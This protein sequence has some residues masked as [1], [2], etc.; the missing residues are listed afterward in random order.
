MDLDG[1]G[2]RNR[3]HTVWGVLHIFIAA[4]TC[5]LL[6]I[7]QCLLPIAVQTAEAAQ[8]LNGTLTNIHGVVKIQRAGSGI[9]RPASSGSSVG[10]GDAVITGPSGSA[11]IKF[12]HGQIELDNATRVT[13]LRCMSSRDEAFAELALS[14]GAVT[15]L[16]NM[17]R[18][19]EL[20]FD[21]IT[22][23][24]RAR[25][26]GRKKSETRLTVSHRA[27]G[28]TV[29]DSE[30]GRWEYQPIIVTDLPP[31]VQAALNNNPKAAE[32]MKTYIDTTLSQTALT[33]YEVTTN[34][35]APDIGAVV[36]PEKI[37]VA[38]TTPTPAVV[39][40]VAIPAPEPPAPLPPPA[41]APTPP[42]EPQTPEP[43]AAVIVPPLSLTVTPHKGKGAVMSSSST[44]TSAGPK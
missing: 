37:S 22:P 26:Q 8:I 38:E 16:I 11:T 17:E 5:C 33:A 2:L 9:E 40:P 39:P 18:G 42:P 4:V 30:V 15:A 10:P 19:K 29:T 3:R 28:T 36:Q 27:G 41:P 6:P 21:I 24:E 43:P 34:S 25:G 31:A 12:D 23:T 32:M 13:L 7:A 1:V 14:D 20:W 35:G 44:V